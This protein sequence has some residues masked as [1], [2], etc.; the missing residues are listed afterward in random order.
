MRIV[1]SSSVFGIGLSAIY[2]H[3]EKRFFMNTV[4]KPVGV[5]VAQAHTSLKTDLVS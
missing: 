2:A 1:S 5:C 4:R 3:A